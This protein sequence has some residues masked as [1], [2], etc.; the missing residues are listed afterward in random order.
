MI[1]AFYTTAD[2]DGTISFPE[3]IFSLY[4]NYNFN[5]NIFPG[6]NINACDLKLHQYYLEL[7]VEYNFIQI[8]FIKLNQKPLPMIWVRALT[9]IHNEK[10][11]DYFYSITT[12]LFTVPFSPTTFN[13]YIPFEMSVRSIVLE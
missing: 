13:K 9:S 7:V 6:L 8:Y 11:A 5:K 2:T 10:K 1:S 12:F 3:P 4:Y